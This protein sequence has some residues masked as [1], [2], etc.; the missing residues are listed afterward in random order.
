MNKN[1]FNEIKMALEKAHMPF[2]VSGAM[3]K[4]TI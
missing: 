4:G 1:I 2:C 3:E